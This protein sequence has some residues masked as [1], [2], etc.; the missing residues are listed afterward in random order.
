MKTLDFY[1]KDI[2]K[3]FKENYSDFD[4]LNQE[5][6]DCISSITDYEPINYTVIDNKKVVIFDSING[7][8]FSVDKLPEFME[9]T[10]KYIQK[11]MKA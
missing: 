7:M 1:G 3:L 10:L 9:E 5:E 8:V 4:K 11:E 6:K 2:L